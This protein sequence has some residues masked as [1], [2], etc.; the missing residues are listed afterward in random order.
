MSRIDRIQI[1]E[2]SFDVPDIGLEQGHLRLRER[3]S[4]PL[5]V[6]EHLRTLE[7]KAAFLVA[8]GCDMI[9]ADP[10]YDLRA[11]NLARF[12]DDDE[13]RA[14]PDRDPRHLG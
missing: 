7:Q 13:C 6:T 1:R 2:F 3:L 9:H 14:V 8:G 4:T 5:L 11:H 10:E 12:A